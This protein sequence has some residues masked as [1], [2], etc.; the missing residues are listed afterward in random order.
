MNSSSMIAIFCC[1]LFSYPLH[2]IAQDAPLPFRTA[3]ELAIRN[4]AATG[5]ARA[6]AQRARANYLQTR[7]LFLPQVTVGS[8]LAFSYGFPLSLEGSAPSILDVNTQEF[9]LNSAQRQFM[10]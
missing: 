1:F 9:L 2:S 3:I 7:D 8:G 4:S 10:K 6:D 5:I